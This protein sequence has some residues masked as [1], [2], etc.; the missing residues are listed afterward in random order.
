MLTTAPA[1]T[2][3]SRCTAEPGEF[4][5]SQTTPSGISVTTSGSLIE[6]CGV[7]TVT[8]SPSAAPIWV[9]DSAESRA[10]GVRAVPAR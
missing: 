7:L 9:A 1:V 8:L 10:T 6:P 5:G 4:S 2:P 3:S